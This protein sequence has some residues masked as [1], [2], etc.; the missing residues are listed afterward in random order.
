M[1]HFD[2]LDIAF[3]H[4]L[5]I[6]VNK[7]KIIEK[8]HHVFRSKMMNIYQVNYILTIN[9]FRIYYVIEISRYKQIKCS[10]TNN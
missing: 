9:T 7:K 8:N 6:T 10:K 4:K 3:Y 5:E 1:L 2:V